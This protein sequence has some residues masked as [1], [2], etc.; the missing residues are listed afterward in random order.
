M[1]K[2]NP[3]FFQVLTVSVLLYGGLVGRAF[4]N[5]P[6][7]QG[8]IPFR[9]IPKTPKRYLMPPCLTLSIIRYGSR[10]KWS[11]PGKRSSALP[12]T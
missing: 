1:R 7:D 5:G 10:V 9:V 11:Y 8:L 4:A 6:G 3:E 2:K 12:Y